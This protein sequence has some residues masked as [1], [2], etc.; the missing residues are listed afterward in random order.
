MSRIIFESETHLDI[1][2]HEQTRSRG[3][4]SANEMEERDAP[5]DNNESC[6]ISGII[7]VEVIVNSNR[8][9]DHFRYHENRIS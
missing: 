1:V 4:L 8:D 9:L 7:K 3:G 2:T 6:V 5:N